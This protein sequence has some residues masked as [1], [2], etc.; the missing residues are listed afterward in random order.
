MH[1]LFN[2]HFGRNYNLDFFRLYE[3]VPAPRF[4]EAREGY[5]FRKGE[6]GLGYY[7][8]RENYLGELK[9]R[10]DLEHDVEG[11]REKE[12]LKR[13]HYDSE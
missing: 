1:S 6:K 7:F 3:F 10:H 13:A 8:D 11:A 4:I 5:V 12:S 9:R 2:K